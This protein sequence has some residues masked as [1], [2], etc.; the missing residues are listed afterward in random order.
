MDPE[1]FHV[2]PEPIVNTDVAVGDADIDAF[3]VASVPAV[4]V[5]SGSPPNSPMLNDGA[6]AAALLNVY[7]FPDSAK[8]TLPCRTLARVLV[9][10]P[11]NVTV[12]PGFGSV[13][14]LKIA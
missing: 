7:V 3:T 6:P 4:T 8:V 5:N 12:Y 11:A 9:M 2:T 10:L 13:A 1:L 14:T